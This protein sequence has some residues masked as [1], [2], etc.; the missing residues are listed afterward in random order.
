M[1]EG[2]AFFSQPVPLLEAFAIISDVSEFAEKNRY[3]NS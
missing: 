2:R 3:S 1:S